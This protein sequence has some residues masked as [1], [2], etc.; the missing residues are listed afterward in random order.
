MRV[1]VVM[2]SLCTLCLYLRAEVSDPLADAVYCF[3]FDQD[4]NGDGFV[5]KEELRDLRCWGSTNFNGYAKTQPEMRIIENTYGSASWVRTNFLDPSRGFVRERPAL[6]FTVD[7]Q[8]VGGTDK[9]QGQMIEFTNGAVPGSVTVLLRVRIDNF[10]PAGVD[11]AN[12]T[13]GGSWLVDNACAN[14]TGTLLGFAYVAPTTKDVPATNAYCRIQAGNA[15]FNGYGVH[16]IYTNI[17]YDIAYTVKDNGNETAD[18]SILVREADPATNPH[19]KHP[20]TGLRYAAGGIGSSDKPAFKKGAVQNAYF[21]LAA[22]GE[23]RD[24]GWSIGPSC[25]ISRLVVWNRAL[26]RDELERVL[27]CDSSAFRIGVENGENG[28]FGEIDEVPDSFNVLSS[29]WRSF[30]KSLSPANSSAELAFDPPGLSQWNFV[31]SPQVLRV[32]AARNSPAGTTSLALDVNGVRHSKVRTVTPGSSVYWVLAGEALH[33]NENNITLTRIG[34]TAPKLDIDVVDFGGSWSIG[35]D[36][37]GNAEFSRVGYIPYPCV[38]YPGSWNTFGCQS[39]VPT[40]PA[41]KTLSFKF[42][43]SELLSKFGYVYSF[44]IDEQGG[45]GAGYDWKKNGVPFKITLNGAANPCFVS[46][47]VPE[48]EVVC[49]EFAP[50]DLTAGWNTITIENTASNNPGCW[51]VFDCHDFKLV[52]FP[53]SMFITVR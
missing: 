39:S 19:S 40:T 21:R 28:E 43:V 9:F 23:W 22:R 51:M 48:G 42:Y 20:T 12:A 8:N 25:D 18:W 27:M 35:S 4:V 45:N 32:K 17:W 49:V 38:F 6:R 29:P 53:D 30:P 26:S 10:A 7:R 37:G 15:S 5:Q 31:K 41:Y 14:G 44:K 2:L 11:H 1:S 36:D 47:G 50:R 3:G 46:A 24:T 34:G 13:K 52:P 16:A 33:V